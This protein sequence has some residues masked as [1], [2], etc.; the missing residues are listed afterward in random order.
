[1]LAERGGDAWA[2]TDELMDHLSEKGVHPQA[3]FVLSK[4]TF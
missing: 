1:M 2:R 3:I 4:T